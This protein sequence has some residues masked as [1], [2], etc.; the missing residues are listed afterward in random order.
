MSDF[1]RTVLFGMAAGI[2]ATIVMDVFVALAMLAMG[3]PVA[4]MFAFIGKV[5][6]TFFSLSTLSASGM[7]ILGF[8]I[9]YLFGMGYGA[10]FCAVL[11]RWPRFRPVAL[12]TSIAVGIAYIEIFSQPFLATAPLVL[13][14]AAADTLQWYALSTA[15][16]AIYGAVL[17]VSEHYRPAI[18]TRS[19][20]TAQA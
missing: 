18:L 5:A 20:A 9:H 14:L 8:V 11:A 12:G 3:F 4:F 15:M 19:P 7:I 17:G 10:L 2:I 6:S 16:H 1:K 13:K